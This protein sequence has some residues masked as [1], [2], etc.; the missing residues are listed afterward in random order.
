MSPSHKPHPPHPLELLDA[1]RERHE[2]AFPDHAAG[3][4]VAWSSHLSALRQLVEIY[5][6]RLLKPYRISYSE[7][8]VLST[9]RTR[10]RDF[11]ATPHDLNRAAQITSAGM[12]RTL[13]RLEAAGH[14]DRIPNPAD[15]RSVLVG[16]TDAGWEFAETIVRDLNARHAE[17]LG[18]VPESERKAELDM[19]RS[20]IGR[21]SAA[22]TG[23]R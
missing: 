13:E 22:V 17:M 5:Y 8:R 12:T 19:L 14:V 18:A 10:P 2:S 11:R 4:E 23:M 15:R 7:Y 6:H 16:L 20:V 9:L 21:I 1:A 3:D